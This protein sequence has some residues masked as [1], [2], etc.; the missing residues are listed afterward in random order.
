MPMGIVMD[1]TPINLQTIG[2][3]LRQGNQKSAYSQSHAPR[4]FSFARIAPLFVERG[5]CTWAVVLLG[6]HAKEFF[7]MKVQRTIWRVSLF[8][9]SACAV[10]LLAT[11]NVAGQPNPTNVRATFQQIQGSAYPKAFTIPESGSLLILGSALA[12]VARQLRRWNT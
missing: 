2:S 5:R 12:V 9:A 6:L 8:S 10:V 1:T 3:M 7:T 4:S 11:G